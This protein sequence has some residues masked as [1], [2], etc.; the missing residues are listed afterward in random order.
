[1]KKI[2]SLVVVL[3]LVFPLTASAIQFEDQTINLYSLSLQELNLL[4]SEVK[5]EIKNNHE[6][7]SSEKES[8]LKALKKYVESHYKNLGL[9]I[10]W[11]WIDYDYTKDWEHFTISTRVDY[12]IEKKSTSDRIYAEVERLNKKYTISYVTIDS[13]PIM[14]ERE[15][16]ASHLLENRTNVQRFSDQSLDLYP[17]TVSELQ[18][19]QKQIRAEINKNHNPSSSEQDAVLQITKKYVS[20]YFKQEKNI[21]DL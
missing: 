2:L 6:P 18:E 17:L 16:Y 19:L 21:E 1:M 10:S 12:K 14:D 9:D 7:S 8:V 15:N 20:A 11:P 3:F 4:E 13:D 5:K